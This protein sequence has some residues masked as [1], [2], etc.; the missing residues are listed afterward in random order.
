MRQQMMIECT[1]DS[2]NLTEIVEGVKGRSMAISHATPGATI[3]G[4]D[5]DL[6]QL[7]A[8]PRK[9]IAV[10][11]TECVWLAAP[12]NWREIDYRPYPIVEWHHAQCSE[13]GVWE[14]N[15]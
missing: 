6:L 13:A 10:P 2:R 7:D 3:D 12:V 5:Y 4:K 8:N 15:S 1:Q 9:A 11:V 14:L